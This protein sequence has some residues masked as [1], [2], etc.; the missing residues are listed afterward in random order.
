M[1]CQSKGRNHPTSPLE[2]ASGM[3]FSFKIILCLLLLHFSLQTSIFNYASVLVSKRSTII[4]YDLNV[5][6]YESSYILLLRAC[7]IENGL[8]F[9]F[10][11]LHINFNIVICDKNP[12]FIREHLLILVKLKNKLNIYNLCIYESI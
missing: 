8:F 6:A 3:H 1:S 2:H 5:H 4:W 9:I 11:K 12:L 10:C 7:N